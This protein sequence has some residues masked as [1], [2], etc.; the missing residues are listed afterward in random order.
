MMSKAD[1]ATTE[2]LI[3]KLTYLEWNYREDTTA[4]RDLVD[5]NVD[6]YDIYPYDADSVVSLPDTASFK[7][8]R[9]EQAKDSVIF[10]IP[11]PTYYQDTLLLAVPREELKKLYEAVQ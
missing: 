10:R 2:R 9:I 11:H 3:D 4:I 6:I 8:V 1:S 5:Y 7:D